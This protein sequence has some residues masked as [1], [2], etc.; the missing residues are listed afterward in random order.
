MISAELLDIPI[1]AACVVVL[2]IQLIL[3]CPV[4][5]LQL[6]VVH[7]CFM[8]RL[9]M[10]GNQ[11]RHCIV[12]RRREAFHKQELQK[13]GQ[14]VIGRF[15]GASYPT[16]VVRKALDA[17]SSSACRLSLTLPAWDAASACVNALHS[18]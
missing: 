6:L 16:C 9:H 18:Q 2:A 7:L 5:L 10:N 15:E 8:Q 3:L 1:D 4:I 11:L 14:V 12:R 17:A 13:Q